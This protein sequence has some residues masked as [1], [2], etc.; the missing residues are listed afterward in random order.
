MSRG[1]ASDYPSDKLPQWAKKSGVAISVPPLKLYTPSSEVKAA[2]LNDYGFRSFV[3]ESNDDYSKLKA[4]VQWA[5]S[6]WKHDGGNDPNTSSPIE[7][8]RLAK[9]GKNFRCVEYSLIA[10]A[11]ASVIGMPSRVVGLR[12]SDVETADYGA[13]HVVA[14][15]WLKSLKK[16][17]FAD[18]QR[19]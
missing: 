11:A 10:A 2:I 6:R 15:V 14:E 17:V 16:W 4:V 3:S 13:G 12:R 5:S 8:L 9:E 7:I 18:S 1:F 19:V